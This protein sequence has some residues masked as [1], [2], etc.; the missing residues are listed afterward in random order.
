[1]MKWC[2]VVWSAGRIP[3]DGKFPKMKKSQGTSVEN[4]LLQHETQIR[5]LKQEI[6]DLYLENKMLKKM[7]EYS[8]HLKKEDSSVIT[9]ENLDQYREPAK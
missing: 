5:N 8:Q 1:M 6:A 3:L 4:K 2:H 7:F 9:S